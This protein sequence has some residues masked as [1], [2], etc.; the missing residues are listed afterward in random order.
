MREEDVRQLIKDVLMDKLRI[1][2]ERDDEYI[3]ARLLYDKV[4]IDYDSIYLPRSN[5][6]HDDD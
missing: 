6:N 5:Y 1:K 2:L 4:T 3:Y